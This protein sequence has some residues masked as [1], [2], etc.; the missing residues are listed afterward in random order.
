MVNILKKNN[1]HLIQ[2]LGA[3]VFNGN[4]KGFVEGT[5]YT[6]PTKGIC[7]PVLNCYSCPGALGACPIGSL[8]A[9][10]GSGGRIGFYVIGLLVLF[11][12][13]LG[14]FFCGFLCPF[15]F[16]QDLL[17]KIKTKKFKVRDSI[18]NKLKYLKY[19]MLIV[20]VIALPIIVAMVKGYS[21]PYFCK[22]ICPAGLIEGAAP[23]LLKNEYLRSAIG[24][25]F[26]WKLILAILFVVSSIFIY[27]PFCKYICPLGAFYGLFNGISFY[28]LEVDQDKCIKCNKCS[29]ICKMHIEPF[30]DPNN[31]ECIRCLDCKGVCPTGAIDNKIVWK[32]NK[33]TVKS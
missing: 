2:A 3:V 16:I 10:S 17:Y 30:K 33:K 23:F 7:V 27:R 19:I 4:F 11:G 25:L 28:K 24:M 13:T 14:R 26:N 20:F 9:V 5:I 1:R 32:E 18:H 22:Y 12:I 15:G 31:S 21:D 6:G 29:K 8:Q